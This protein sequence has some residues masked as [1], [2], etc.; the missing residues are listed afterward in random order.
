[1][2]PAVSTQES[3]LRSV[4]EL[5]LC[6]HPALSKDEYNHDEEPP[7]SNEHPVPERCCNSLVHE[8]LLSSSTHG[9]F[10]SLP[11]RTNSGNNCVS[12]VLAE[13]RSMSLEKRWQPSTHRLRNRQRTRSPIRKK[14][15]TPEVSEQSGY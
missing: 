13:N 12:R 11:T 7:T 6:S 15:K 4:G 5:L 10:L 1:M 3:R 2:P 8:R 14:E 9:S